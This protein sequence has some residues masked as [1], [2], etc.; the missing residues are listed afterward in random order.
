MFFEAD[1]DG[2]ALSALSR[3]DVRS[4]ARKANVDKGTRRRL[5]DA[6][7]ELKED[8][9]GAEWV[10]LYGSEWLH[11]QSC[12]MWFS[13]HCMYHIIVFSIILELIIIV[14]ANTKC[15]F[16]VWWGLVHEFLLL[17][18]GPEVL[19]R[20]ACFVALY[21]RGGANAA[22]PQARLTGSIQGIVGGVLLLLPCGRAK[23]GA[24]LSAHPPRRIAHHS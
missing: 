1:I 8:G 7:G 11:G 21:V 12:N 4:L 24:C 18:P 3:A 19:R 5:Y 13:N 16:D 23:G 20:I 2:R 10:A 9:A 22:C 14:L 15:V 6:V 17:V